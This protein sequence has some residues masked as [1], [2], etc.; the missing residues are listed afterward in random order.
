MTD[1]RCIHEKRLI[2]VAGWPVLTP[3]RRR[4]L[5]RP[6][7][8]LLGH[9]AALPWILTASRSLH[10]RTRQERLSY[11]VRLRHEDYDA[12]REIMVDSPKN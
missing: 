12:Q 7:P 9:H 1:S 3:R 10:R 5:E 6:P 8:G 4:R 2:S 11:S